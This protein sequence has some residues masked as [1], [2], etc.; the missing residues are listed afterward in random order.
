MQNPVK[1]CFWPGA[2]KGGRLSAVSLFNFQRSTAQLAT[3]IILFA[4]A[5]SELDSW[6]GMCHLRRRLSLV[7]HAEEVHNECG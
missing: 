7:F 4:M 2:L 6:P 1:F 5:T 3:D